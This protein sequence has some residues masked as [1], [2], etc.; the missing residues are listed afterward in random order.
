MTIEKSSAKFP[1]LQVP[2]YLTNLIAKGT[3]A[4]TVI[5]LA[6]GGYYVSHFLLPGQEGH[7]ESDPAPEVEA[8]VGSSQPMSVRL[9]PEK[10]EAAGIVSEVLELHSFQPHRVFPGRISYNSRTRVDIRSAV[11]SV[12]V[13]VLVHVGQIVRTG[14]PLLE[15]SSPEVGQIRAGIQQAAAQVT[16]V[17]TEYDWVQTTNTHVMD[18]LAFLKQDPTLEQI[19]AAFANRPMGDHRNE[20]LSTY[21][22]YLLA[23]K[24]FSRSTNDETQGVISSRVI[25]ERRSNWESAKAKLSG[26]LE[27]TEFQTAQDAKMATAKLAAAKQDLALQQERLRSLLGPF[28]QDVPVASP[29][30][31]GNTKHET[32]AEPAIASLSGFVLLAPRD[33]IVTELSATQASRFESGDTLLTLADTDSVWVEAQIPQRDLSTIR[34][35]PGDEIQVVVGGADE[36]KFPAVVQHLSTNISSASLAFPLVAE[37]LNTDLALRPGMLVWVRVPSDAPRDRFGVPE[38]AIQRDGPSAFVFSRE[39]D[40]SFLRRDV[41]IGE[42]FDGWIEIETSIP[43]GTRLVTQGSFYLKSELLLES[44]E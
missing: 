43:P 35:T 39:P 33:G 26:L 44:E 17:E 21:S 41:E 36:R 24:T 29:D 16:V 2:E 6:W 14:E 40:G 5:A 9:S 8:D 32:V 38:S 31:Q 25:D 7:A 30:R 15:L 4:A 19:E 13:N 34:C 37:L 42:E 10:I 12:V 3:A 27:E 1:R 23:Q 28:F 20:I 11:D 22:Q 18:L